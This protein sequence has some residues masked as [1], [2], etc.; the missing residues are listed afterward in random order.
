MCD[1]FDDSFLACMM[2]FERFCIDGDLR[3]ETWG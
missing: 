2:G 1:D 3:M